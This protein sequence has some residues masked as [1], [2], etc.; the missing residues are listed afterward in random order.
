MINHGNIV[1]QIEAGRMAQLPA[2][3]G[4][5]STVLE[6]TGRKCRLTAHEYLNTCVGVAY[7]WPLQ[8]PRQVTCKLLLC[9]GMRCILPQSSATDITDV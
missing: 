2:A 3:S 7:S 6:R 9:Q 5:T 4:R 8:P 1:G